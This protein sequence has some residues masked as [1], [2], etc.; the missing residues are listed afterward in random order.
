MGRKQI[1]ECP[2]QY[3][4][5]WKEGVWWADE[6]AVSGKAETETSGPLLPQGNP[7]EGS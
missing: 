4:A 2:Q 5:K 1:A 3:K 7:T 6:T